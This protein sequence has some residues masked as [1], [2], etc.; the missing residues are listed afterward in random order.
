MKLVSSNVTLYC[1]FCS[2][3]KKRGQQK[4]VVFSC[5]LEFAL[6]Y[7][8]RTEKKKNTLL[9]LHPAQ[10]TSVDAI[11][12]PPKYRGLLHDALFQ[13]GYIPFFIQHLSISKNSF[14]SVG[15]HTGIL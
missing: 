13:H 12:F 2:Q 6:R 15:K 8:K 4:K 1:Q 11:N 3:A 14:Q 7:S 10:H 5:E 9:K